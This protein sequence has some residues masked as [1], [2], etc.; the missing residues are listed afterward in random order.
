MDVRYRSNFQLLAVTMQLLVLTLPA[1][2]FAQD[3]T[4]PEI[5]LTSQLEVDQF[6]ANHGPCDRVSQNL[7]ITGEDI[8]SF[9]GLS[10]LTA[11]LGDL[12][13][14][15]NS[16]LIT[17][18]GLAKL[19]SV[20]SL[21]I[22][23]NPALLKIDGL[24]GLTRVDK[25]LGIQ[26]NDSLQNVGG[27]NQLAYV[28]DNLLVRANWQLTSLHGLSKLYQVDGTLQFS[29]NFLVDLDGFSSLTS[30]GGLSIFIEGLLTNLD[31]LSNLTDVMGD[32][33]IH[34]NGLTTIDG[35]SALARVG[36]DLWL[37]Q[38][39]HL[40]NCM[41]ITQ[42]VDQIDDADPGPGVGVAP[43]VG[44]AILIEQ[45]AI[46]C[47]S[48]EEILAEEPLLEMNAGLNDAWFNPGTDGQGF[49]IIVYPQIEQIFLAW[50]TYDIVRP[51]MDVAASVGEPGHRW[52]TAQGP[53]VGN[54]ASLTLYNTSGGIFDSAEPVPS[55]QPDGTV[56]LEFSS[57]SRGTI[58]YDIDSIGWQGPVPIERIVLDNIPLCEALNGQ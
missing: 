45:N 17:I 21:N 32:L 29:G 6:Q 41:G 3:C 24:S 22:S 12:K 44:G 50:F 43:D 28:G 8:V 18:D 49:L 53:F 2:A 40:S 46:G 14:G 47:N 39:I 27:L 51:P 36:G 57:C 34:G 42:L 26:Y 25:W 55:S 4:P 5:E 7:V 54:R 20:G 52:L 16:S 31:G 38:N 13:I 37:L 33:Y 19:Q 15:G 11:V 58:K 10:D 23:F 9:D 1:L 30:V 56:V 48:V 35:L